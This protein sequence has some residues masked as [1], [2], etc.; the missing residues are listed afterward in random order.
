MANIILFDNEIRNFFLPLA[1]T[2]P[3]CEIRIG[4]LTISEKW[5]RWLG[6]EISYITQDYLAEKYPI[7][8]GKENY[9]ING[10]AL[11][12]A[13]LCRLIQQMEFNEAFLNGEE[14]VVAK[15]DE[16]QFERLIHDED[17][18][19]LK[20]FDLSGT[21]YIKLNR[22]WDIFHYNDK[23]LQEDFDLI[24]KGRTSQPISETNRILGAE[25]IFL[26]EGACVEFSTINATKGPVYIGKNA[27]IMEG[28]LIR[29][30]LALCDHAKLKMGTRIYGATTLGPYS[31][32]GG[33]VNNSVIHSNSNKGHDGYLGNSVIGDWCNLGAG[34][35]NS[36]LKNN[37]AE[38]RVWDYSTEGFIP[39]G[40]QFCGMIMGDHSKCAI[41]TTFNTGTVIGTS[42]NIYGPGF[43]R[44]FVPSFSWG[45]AHGFQT[46]QT[47]K[48]FETIERVLE[49]RKQD[50]EIPDRLIM[51]RIF[52]DTAKFRRWE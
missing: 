51:L 38:V 9:L 10:S 32:A 21:D 17:I 8:Y 12:S 48:A 35:N 11:P 31:K 28:C 27:E 40:H 41:N 5:Q 43:P 50:F 16:E 34:T 23:A 13:Q 39:T 36:N 15:L 46:Y 1:Y 33:E 18:G 29:G 22:L 19:E 52:E 6:G 20:G 2:R 44:N 14:L 45:G 37:Y 4:I 24:T 3:V 7:D 42:T 49:R 25:N 26:E 47:D 30:G